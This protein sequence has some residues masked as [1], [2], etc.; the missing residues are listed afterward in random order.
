MKE[1]IIYQCSSC[2]YQSLKWVGRCPGCD[3]WNTVEETIVQMTKKS[4]TSK[5]NIKKKA[6]TLKLTDVQGSKSDRIVTQINEFNRVMGGGIVRDSMTIITSPPGGGKSTLT[7]AVANDVAA[8]GYKVLYASG[9]ESDSQIKNRADRILNKINENIWIIA[10]TSMDHVLE[11]IEEIDPDLVIV[12]SIQTFSLS[13]HL[14]A[15][16]GNPTQ[17]MECSNE[18][19]KV[20]KNSNKPRA[21]I[22]IGQMNKNDEI[23]GLRS[24][25]HLVDTVLVI[26]GEDEAELR[27]ILATK[28]RFGSTGEMGF[29][30][31]TER[32]LLSIDNPSEFFMT[33]RE[34][35]EVV[36]G[37]ALT[38]LR[39]GSRPIIVEIESLVSNAFTPYPSRIGEA[40]RREQ[41]NTLISI[42]EQRG[43]INLFNKNVVIK[44]TGGIKLKEQAVNLAVIMSIA[45]S[46]YNKGIANDV[47]FIA[48]VGLTGELKKVPALEARIKEL[49]RMGFKKV[50]I[51]KNAFSK[52]VKFNNIDVVQLKTL[53]EVIQQVFSGGKS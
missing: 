35:G 10:D 37:S 50:Y 49:D 17:T 39:E 12:D 4:T 40:F 27:G 45:S 20:A 6:P 8:K 22:M 5:N 29:F 24:L 33:K 11:T 47:V 42:L 2:G 7:L 16:A 19:L 51:A 52:T 28:N 25:E 9:E 43:G 41:L 13:Q 34:E 3:S 30:S 48:D 21:V 31:M 14:P 53:Q 46:V 44:T 38:V 36:S 15:R 32:G 1:K 18:L 23:A 26:E